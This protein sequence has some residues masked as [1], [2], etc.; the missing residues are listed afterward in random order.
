MV[1]KEQF[2][3]LFLYYLPLLNNFNRINCNFIYI[4]PV[5]LSLSVKFLAAYKN[6]FSYLVSK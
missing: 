4:F 5:C 1:E 3:N 2:V 6:L